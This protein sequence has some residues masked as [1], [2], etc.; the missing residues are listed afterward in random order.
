MRSLPGY[1]VVPPVVLAR[2]VPQALCPFR[3][4]VIDEL[5]RKLLALRKWGDAK[6]RAGDQL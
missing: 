4:R 1:T 6:A 3:A 2:H 5:P